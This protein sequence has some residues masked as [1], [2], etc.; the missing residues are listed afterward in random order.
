M[1]SEYLVVFARVS[2]M[3]KQ[4]SRALLTVDEVAIVVAEALAEVE[5]A[6]LSVALVVAYARAEDW[7]IV[8]LEGEADVVGRVAEALSI[9][10]QVA[11]S[12]Q[13]AVS[14]RSNWRSRGTVVGANVVVQVD[15]GVVVLS[16]APLETSSEDVAIVNANVLSRVVERHFGSG[17]GG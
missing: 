5:V 15:L 4:V 17:V 3:N 13:S 16:I 7:D 1:S 10:E 2:Y 6:L 9:P 12:S 11:C 14:Q 8:A